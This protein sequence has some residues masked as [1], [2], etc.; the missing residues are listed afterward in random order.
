MS[1]G[2]S[3]RLRC[4]QLQDFS[5]VPWE[6]QCQCLKPKP[7]FGTSK[8]I[9]NK[10]KKKLYST[11]PEIIIAIQNCKW[12]AGCRMSQLCGDTC[13][14]FMPVL[15][16]LGLQTN[17]WSI[18]KNASQQST[19]KL[20]PQATIYRQLHAQKCVSVG[21]QAISNATRGWRHLRLTGNQQSPGSP[22]FKVS[23]CHGSQRGHQRSPTAFDSL[24]QDGTGCTMEQL[25]KWCVLN[26]VQ[27]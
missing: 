26:E 17:W 12:Q 16:T 5:P 24:G 9:N 13:L 25:L 14:I 18:V 8:E 2:R 10:L 6:K 27:K 3:C 15:P 11:K 4:D 19:F 7:L 21:K 22:D 20:C 1:T 23:N